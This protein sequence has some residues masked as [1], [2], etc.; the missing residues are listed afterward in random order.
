MLTFFQKYSFRNTISV[1]NGFDP[2]QDPHSVGPDLGAKVI[3]RR[4]KS[5]KLRKLSSAVAVRPTLKIFLFPLTQPCFTSM[6]QLVRF[7]FLTSQTRYPLNLI[8]RSP[9]IGNKVKYTNNLLTQNIFFKDNTVYIG[10]F[11]KFALKF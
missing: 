5:Q 11:S 1:S 7:F 9:T 2:D 8:V 4:Q 6:G 10:Q 3:S